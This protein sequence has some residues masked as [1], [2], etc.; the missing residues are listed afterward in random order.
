MS[1]HTPGSIAALA[2]EARMMP[3]EQSTTDVPFSARYAFQQ[4][5]TADHYMELLEALRDLADAGEEAWGGER[6][7][8]S[9]ARTVIA[10]ATGE[11]A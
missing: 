2:E 5:I 1:K 6:P 4:A 11:S 8:V 7:C 10:K 3:W 9:W